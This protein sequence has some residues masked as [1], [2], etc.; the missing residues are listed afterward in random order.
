[1]CVPIQNE[2]PQPAA[3]VGH[4]VTLPPEGTLDACLATVVL[5]SR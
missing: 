1:M 5:G 2:K 3:G 4:G